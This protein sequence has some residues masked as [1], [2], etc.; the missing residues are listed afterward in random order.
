VN[1][2]HNTTNTI[3]IINSFINTDFTIPKMIELHKRYA[4]KIVLPIHDW[5]WYV[6]GSGYNEEY[7][8]IY[9]S[10]ELALP[11]LSRQLF[12][13]SDKIICPTKFVYR[14]SQLFCSMD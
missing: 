6:L 2:L 8:S 5:Y 13:I 7:H 10:T 3:V 12:D 1:Q 14:F 11:Y 4:F 9:L